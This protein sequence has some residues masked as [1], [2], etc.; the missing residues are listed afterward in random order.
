MMAMPATSNWRP[1]AETVTVSIPALA[2][3]AAPRKADLLRWVIEVVRIDV[4]RS[5]AGA[6]TRI[7][8]RRTPGRILITGQARRDA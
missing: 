8:I 2:F 6:R 5:N 7:Q 1:D 3:A 4:R